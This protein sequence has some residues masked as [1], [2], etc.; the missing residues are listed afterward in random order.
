MFLRKLTDEE[1]E[2]IK[3]SKE[4]A[5]KVI[6]EQRKKL[7]TEIK[8]YQRKALS[9]QV[10]L[11]IKQLDALIL[12]TGHPVIIKVDDESLCMNYDL[13]KKF[14]VSFYKG[15]FWT[16]DLKI[17]GKS[18]FISYQKH[19]NRGTVELFE[20]P[21]HQVELLKGLPLIDLKDIEFESLL[22]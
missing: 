3:K 21:A 5:N 20:L 12:I 17:E 6:K 10:S 14:A 22:A 1:S 13:L 11:L 19:P 16:T 9:H 18:L 8:A 7:L 15:N 4:A 2:R